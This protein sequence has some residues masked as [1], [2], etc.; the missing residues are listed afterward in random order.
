MLLDHYNEHVV[1]FTLLLASQDMR[2]RSP[3]FVVQRVIAEGQK[4]FRVKEKM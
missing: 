3:S 4:A 1:F 2:T